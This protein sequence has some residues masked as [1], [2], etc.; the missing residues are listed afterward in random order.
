[1]APYELTEPFVRGIL[2]ISVVPVHADRRVFDDVGTF[3]Q[4]QW[5]GFG[6]GGGNCFRGEP[7]EIR[8][9]DD[10]RGGHE[11]GKSEL[12]PRPCP[13]VNQRPLKDQVFASLIFDEHEFEALQCLGCQ[14]PG[15]GRMGVA[16]DENVPLLK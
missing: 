4:D 1:M 14:V 7:N 3:P 13:T 10:V 2:V 11:L 12:D 6:D 8:T 9:G 5:V 16:H 15:C